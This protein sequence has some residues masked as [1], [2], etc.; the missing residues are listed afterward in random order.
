MRY[1]LISDWSKEA[2]SRLFNELTVELY[3]ILYSTDFQ[4]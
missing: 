3:Q 4:K 2:N 1:I